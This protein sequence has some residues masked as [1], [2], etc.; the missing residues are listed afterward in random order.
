MEVDINRTQKGLGDT[1]VNTNP[2]FTGGRVMGLFLEWGDDNR[3]FVLHGTVQ[4]FAIIY[5]KVKR[6]IPIRLGC[7]VT[8]FLDR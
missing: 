5:E 1:F 3:K 2:T 8:S 7:S 6:L 4:I